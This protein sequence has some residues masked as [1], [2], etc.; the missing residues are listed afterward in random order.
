MGASYAGPTPED[1]TPTPRRAVWIRGRDPVELMVLAVLALL[2]LWVLGW[3][4]GRSLENGRIWTGID[5]LHASDPAL[6][7]GFISSAAHSILISNLF[8]IGPSTQAFLHPG[9][10]LSALLTHVGISAWLALLLWKP[11]AVLAFFAAVRSYVHGLL[12]APG[13]RRA[14]LV[15]ALFFVPTAAYLASITGAGGRTNLYLLGIEVDVW[16]GTWLWG[17]PFTLIAVA[18]IPAALLL[19]ERDRR[20]GRIGVA[21]PAAALVCSWLQPW[22]GATLLGILAVSE[23]VDWGLRRRGRPLARVGNPEPA[24]T[25]SPELTQRLGLLAVNLAAGAAPLVYYAAL[26]RS[27]PSWALSGAA[28]KFGG[29]P[30]WA[31]GLSLAPLA[32]PALFAYLKRPLSWSEIALRVWPVVG[33]AVYWVI[34][35]GGVGT[36]PL[37]AFQGLTIPLGILAVSGV[38]PW[39][40]SGSRRDQ[41]VATALVVVLVVPALIWKMQ[42]AE[43]STAGNSVS[44]LGGPPNTYFLTTG[45]ANALSFLKHD[46]LPGGVLASAAIGEVTPGRTGRQTWV[47]VPSFTPDYA[48]RARMVELLLTGTLDGRRAIAF[49]RATRARYVLIDCEHHADVSRQIASIVVGIRRFGCATLVNISTSTAHAATV[50]PPGPLRLPPALQLVARSM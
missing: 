13:A 12:P 20:R 25:P 26:E 17:Y 47:G 32:L 41:L 9:F 6:Y 8:N 22:Q 30:L 29:W 36:F 40:T 16:P 11:I 31:I 45:E 50:L 46:P 43:R 48:L 19:Y 3:L 39:F 28:N 10:L 24:R 18:A 37:H 4:F 5:G 33:L 49:V 14:A 42:D 34:A 38:R 2:S 35:L 1:R 23:L 7:T 27:D 15:L 21:G 44:L